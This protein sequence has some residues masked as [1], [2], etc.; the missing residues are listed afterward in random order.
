MPWMFESKIVFAEP[1]MLSVAIF[2]MNW[3]ISMLVG[4]AVWQGAS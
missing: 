4:Q 3:G 2:R 1:Q